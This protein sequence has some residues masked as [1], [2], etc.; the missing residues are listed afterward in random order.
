MSPNTPLLLARKPVPKVWGGRA[1]ETRMGVRLPAGQT[2]GE[3][4]LLYD[5]PGGSSSVAGG[6]STLADL[7]KTDSEAILGAGVAAGY[8]GRFPLLLKLIDAREAL[9]LQVHPDDAQARG[10]GDGGK[11]EACVVLH[12]GA[13]AR[14]ISGLL[15][16]VTREQFE[17]AVDT[18]EI[19]QM[20]RAF[21]PNI[22]DCIEVP[23]GTV[24]AIGPDVLAFEVEQNSEIT[25]RLND[26]GRP[27]DTH[28]DKGLAVARAGAVD[29][30]V[31]LPQTLPDG[32]SLLV[33]NDWFRVR[34]YDL[35]QS[36]PMPTGGRYLTLTVVGGRGLVAPRGNAKAEPLR[37]QAGDTVLVPACAS[38]A[39]VSPIGSLDIIACDPGASG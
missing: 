2:I 10:E 30:P 7:M 9:S 18:P 23:T 15:P 21:K 3:V 11:H 8:G 16:G 17:A 19:E 5:R 37:V 35:R 33:Q 13:G 6:S 38:E 34:R 29:V 26:W 39:I 20:V 32:G 28:L 12:A 4:W 14:M 25:Y 31:C 1:L 27:R 24:H 22:G 36:H